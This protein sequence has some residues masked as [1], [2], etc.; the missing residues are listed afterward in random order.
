M[1][2]LGLPLH[3]LIVHAAVI[4]IP[5]AAV[6][7]LLMVFSTRLRERYGWLTVLVAVGATLAAG[8]A[9]LTGP[10]LAAELGLTGS[11]RVAGHQ[12][13]GQLTPWPVLVLTLA[14]AGFRYL[15]GRTSARTP[16]V[17][18][19]GIVT[20]LAAVA[21]LVLV[22]LTGHAGATAVWG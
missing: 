11:P 2:I 5:L 15:T 14:L 12:F 7:A 13:L 18:I 10:L 4:L 21:A 3:P 1:H 8:A 19:T 16:A 20:G 22:G 6:G 9:A 17:L